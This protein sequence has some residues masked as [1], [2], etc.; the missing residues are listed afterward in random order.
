MK[1]IVLFAVLVM[2]LA[3]T[4]AGCTKRDAQ[5]VAPDA[6]VEQ[7][8]DAGTKPA[9]AGARDSGVPVIDAEVLP[10][11]WSTYRN[12]ERG[13]AFNYPSG[14]TPQARVTNN[15][16]GGEMVTV[17]FWQSQPPAVSQDMADDRSPRIELFIEGTG[18]EQVVT[19]LQPVTRRVSVTIGDKEYT[20]LEE[21]VSGPGIE[22][23]T[24]M[25]RYLWSSGGK[26]YDLYGLKDEQA[27][28]ERILSNQ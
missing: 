9:D 20:M 28:I 16:D 25:V 22:D 13:I 17:G 18:L 1:H 19:R 24:T 4:G 5:P 6:A 12:T 21:V 2:A 23:D 14:Y 3:M 8:K 26:T 27:V 7:E 10:A 11:G 15:S